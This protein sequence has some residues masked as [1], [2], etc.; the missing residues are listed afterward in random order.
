MA[1]T[2]PLS[3][4]PS[5]NSKFSEMLK[6]VTRNLPVEWQEAEVVVCVMPVWCASVPV[7]AHTQSAFSLFHV[8]NEEIAL[9]GLCRHA[10]DD[11]GSLKSF[12]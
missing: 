8:H 2:A 6:T 11:F 10:C 1:D 7:R 5:K 4:T 12:H 3:D 9:G